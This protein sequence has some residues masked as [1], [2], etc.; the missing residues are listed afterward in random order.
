MDIATTLQD[1][2]DEMN[3]AY[4]KVK[5]VRLEIEA[6]RRAGY[7]GMNTFDQEQISN[8]YKASYTLENIAVPELDRL[9]SEYDKETE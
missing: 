8:L 9:L 3:N 6:C 2:E 1:I 4:S 5:L 7:S